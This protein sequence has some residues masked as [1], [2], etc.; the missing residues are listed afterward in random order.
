MKLLLPIIGVGALIGFLLAAYLYTTTQHR[1]ESGVTISGITDINGVI[2][3]GSTLTF[4]QRAVGTTEKP[5]PFATSLSPKDGIEWV[6]SKAKNNVSYE[7]SATLSKDGKTLAT[8]SP[9]FLTAPAKNERIVLNIHTPNQTGTAVISGT[10]AL[11]GYI[12]SS[13]V[14][15]I[16]GRKL[17]AASWTTVAS[18]LPAKN[19]QFMS[20]T[21]AVS[22]QVYEV[23]G[24]LS[25]GGI[26]IGES[27]ILTLT[28]PA[29]NE[30]LTINSTAQPPVTPIPSQTAGPTQTPA[31]NTGISGTIDF[32]GQA[33]PNTRITIFQAPAGSTNF[34]LAVDNISPTDGATWT[35]N[36][37]TAGQSYAMLAILKQ[38]QSNGSDIDMSDSS[39]TTVSAPASNLI[40]TINSGF[41]LPAAGGTISVNCGNYTGSNQTW[42]VTVSFSN[43]PNA[44]SYWYQVGVTNGGDELTNFTQNATN[45]QTQMAS[46]TFQN[47]VTYFARYAYATVANLPAGSTQFS[48][49]SQT[50]PLR[51]AQ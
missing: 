10:I 33:P 18:N 22:G 2:P 38:K 40:F 35:W 12:P 45:S 36:G 41:S 6:F 19:D 46:L 16:R 5:T 27:S 42:G 51:C 1:G 44:A 17:G 21:T 7:L 9:I 43:M 11:N 29:E 23:Q 31:A 34:Q 50:T 4:S 15:T 32:N 3:N 14:I 39:T 28:A 47:G 24:F 30:T 26:Q 13:A 49:F 20:Y 25:S 48:P 8:A 37:A